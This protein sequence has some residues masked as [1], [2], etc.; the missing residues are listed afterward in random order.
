MEMTDGHSLFATKVSFTNE[1]KANFCLQRSLCRTMALT[2]MQI[3]TKHA[4]DILNTARGFWVFLFFFFCLVFFVL[5][6][7]LKKPQTFK[8][9][10]LKSTTFSFF[11][12]LLFPSS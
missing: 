3:L 9:G 2:L 4:V 10:K 11:F 5:F 6:C 12:S 1:I 7:F 8:A